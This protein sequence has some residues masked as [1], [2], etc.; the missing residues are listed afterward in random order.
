MR[1]SRRR[2]IALG[3]A[4]GAGILGFG[5]AAF[6]QGRAIFG[7]GLPSEALADPLFAYSAN[8]FRQHLGTEFMLATDSMAVYA[9]L[10]EVS[11][12]STEKTRRARNKRAECFTLTFRLLS[13]APQ[14]TYTVS[15]PRLRTF[16]LLLVPGQSVEAENLL[17]A[18]VNRL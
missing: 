4:A 16:D 18:V 7:G 5:G 17:H 9:V 15:H 11:S 3:S 14:A 10:T 12:F 1:F 13:D 2:F 6:G 8:N